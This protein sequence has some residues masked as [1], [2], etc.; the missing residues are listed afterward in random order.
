MICFKTLRQVAR[1]SL[2]LLSPFAF[3]ATQSVFPVLTYEPYAVSSPLAMAEGDV[4]GDGIP[5]TVY[6]SASTTAG[7]SALTVSPRSAPSAPLTSIA[8]GTVPCTANSI[9]LADLNKDQRLDAVVTCSDNNVF[10]MANQGGGTFTLAGQINFYGRKAQ[11]ADFNGDGFPD[12]VIQSPVFLAHITSPPLIPVM[13]TM[14]P[15]PPTR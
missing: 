8:A 4:T 14:R 3:A 1:A 12:L 10:V 11:A 15:P 2:C 7:S 5:D 9:L 13:Q 6:A